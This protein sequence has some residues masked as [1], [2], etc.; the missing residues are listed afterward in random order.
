VKTV[1]EQETGRQLGQMFLTFEEKPI[2]SA[3]IAQV[4]RARLLTG[5][6][7]A[8]K[9]QHPEL[10]ENTRFDLSLLSGFVELAEWMFPQFEYRWLAEELAKNLPKELNF[11][12][13]ASNI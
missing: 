3:S 7:V 5:E 4:H 2:A 10:I 8:V 9:V 12:L 1:V 13:E 6:E 11:T